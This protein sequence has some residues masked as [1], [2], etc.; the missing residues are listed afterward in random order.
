MQHDAPGMGLVRLFGNYCHAQAAGPGPFDDI[1]HVLF[2]T[3]E[4]EPFAA[5]RFQKK[6]FEVVRDARIASVSML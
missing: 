6:T 5:F 1:V 3:E 2:A 4:R